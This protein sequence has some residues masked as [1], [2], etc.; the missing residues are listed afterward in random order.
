[1]DANLI[2]I[3]CVFVAALVFAIIDYVVM[4]KWHDEEFELYML[5]CEE[6]DKLEK[7]LDDLLLNQSIA[8]RHRDN[9]DF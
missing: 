8:S 4:K 5:T 3:I 7:T 9:D 1:M 6:I 2:F